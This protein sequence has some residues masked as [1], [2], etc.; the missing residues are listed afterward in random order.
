MF[1]CDQCGL[2][3]MH[4]NRAVIDYD[5][6]MENGVCRYFNKRTKLCEIYDDRPIFCNVDKFYEK[7]FRDKYSRE[8]YYSVNYDICNK[9]KE[10]Y[11]K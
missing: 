1:K 8:D 6:N 7:Y 4:V 5:I 10:R 3:C 11:G 9:L 2:C